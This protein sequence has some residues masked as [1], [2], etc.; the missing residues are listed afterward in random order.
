MKFINHVN[1]YALNRMLNE[2]LDLDE[3]MR[4]NLVIELIEENTYWI[5]YIV[6]DPCYCID[7][8]VKITELPYESETIYHF[9]IFD[10]VYADNGDFFLDYH[11]V[12]DK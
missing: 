8:K 6:D 7:F 10:S 11:L 1:N 3:D 4:E 5:H 12:S 9:H 2:T